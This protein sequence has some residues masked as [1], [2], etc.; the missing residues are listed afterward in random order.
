VEV[1]HTES[2]A[3]KKVR[4]AEGLLNKE[5]SPAAFIACT[6]SSKWLSCKTVRIV[7]EDDVVG[8]LVGIPVETELGK[9]VG[10]PVAPVTAL[11]GIELTP[12][13]ARVLEPCACIVETTH[14]ANKQKATPNCLIAII[15]KV[16]YCPRVEASLLKC[17][18]G[19]MLLGKSARL[20]EYKC[21]KQKMLPA[22]VEIEWD[23]HTWSSERRAPVHCVTVHL[24]ES[25]PTPCH[26]LGT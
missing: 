12:V 7:I 5:S 17:Y 4:V 24:E 15:Q 26:F 3:A 22:K 9:L 6:V 11:V 8:T 23:A 13:G 1:D 10:I 21:S 2:F 25:F 16:I 18:D 20:V 19:K 14:M